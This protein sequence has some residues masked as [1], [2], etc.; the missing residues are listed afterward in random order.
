M[1]FSAVLSHRSIVEVPVE[2]RRYALGVVNLETD[3]T[4]HP[5]SIARKPEDQDHDKQ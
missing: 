5:P 3:S 2:R 4:V 1:H